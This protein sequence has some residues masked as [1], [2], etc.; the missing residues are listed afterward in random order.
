M[1]YYLRKMVKIINNGWRYKYLEGIKFNK[2]P[3]KLSKDK[4]IVGFIRR[5]GNGKYEFI[6]SEKSRN[7]VK[8]FKVTKLNFR[9]IA[10]KKGHPI[11]SK[12]KPSSKLTTPRKSLK[13]SA[14]QM[15]SK[16]THKLLTTSSLQ[17]QL[18]KQSTPRPTSKQ[19]TKQI[20]PRLTSITQP[21][22]TSAQ[23]IIPIQTQPKQTQPV[24]IPTRL[25]SITQPIQAPPIQIIHPAPQMHPPPPPMMAPKPIPKKRELKITRCIDCK[26]PVKWLPGGGLYFCPVCGTDYK[27]GN[28]CSECGAEVVSEA[29]YCPECGNMPQEGDGEQMY[30]ICFNC[31]TP[32][33]GDLDEGI[34]YCPEC[35]SEYKNGRA[36]PICVAKVAP[37][38]TQCSECGKVLEGGEGEYMYHI[39]SLHKTQMEWSHEDGYFCLQCMPESDLDEDDEEEMYEYDD[40]W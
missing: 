32:V 21:I 3:H 6:C 16:P 40:Q 1:V 15:N 11:S 4:I 30:I 39:C 9:A 37:E 7:I 27:S 26:T 8:K 17:K 24:Q 34:Y 22:R 33:E 36:C 29:T 13:H 38:A 10:D 25:P 28:A 31:E 23:Q 35:R 19:S 14:R 18:P 5:W 12:P 20:T 2:I